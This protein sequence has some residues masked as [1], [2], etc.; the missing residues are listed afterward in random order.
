MRNITLK[1]ILVGDSYTG[2][3]SLLHALNNDEFYNNFISTI[4]VDFKTIRVLK[5]DIIFKLY[6]WDTSGQEK[7]DAIIRAYF[8][9]INCAIVLY[10][11]SD[12]NSFLNVEKWIQ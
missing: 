3:T 12:Y 2:K 11:I 4:G 5:N 10:D 6:I 9:N 7:F 8:R 1:T